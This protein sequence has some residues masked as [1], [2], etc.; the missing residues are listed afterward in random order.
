MPLQLHFLGWHESLL[1]LAAERLSSGFDGGIPDMGRMLIVTPTRQS[2]HKLREMLVRNAAERKSGLFPPR[3]VTPDFFLKN[4][5]RRI[6][7]ATEYEMIAAWAEILS[8]SAS[9]NLRALKITDRKDFPWIVGLA[10]KFCELRNLLAENSYIIADVARMGMTCGLQEPERWDALARL[11]RSYLEKLDKAGLKDANV[12]KIESD[13]FSDEIRDIEKI[14]LI[15]VCDP[16]QLVLGK[17]KNISQKKDVEIWVYAPEDMSERFDGW[18]CPIPEKWENA[19]IDF[20]GHEERIRLAGNPEAQA[21]DIVKILSEGRKVLSTADVAVSVLNE[22]LVPYVEKTF[23]DTGVRTFNP[24]GDLVSSTS[25]FHL[26]QSFSDL[27]EQENY[28]AFAKFARNP[29]FLCRLASESADFSPL[30]FLKE[31]DVYQNRHLPEKLADLEHAEHKNLKI[32]Y[33]RIHALIRE[34]KKIPLTSFVRKFLS[35]TFKSRELDPEKESSMKF[36]STAEL[37][38]D[39]LS[40]L[41]KSSIESIRLA[42]SEKLRLFVHI[43]E[44]QRIYPEHESD[45]LP[46]QG[47]LELPWEKAESLIVAGMNEGYVPESVIGDIFIPD[48]P[49]EKLGLKNNRRRFARDVYVMTSIIESR[50]NGKLYC[51]AGK[52]DVS[53]EPLKPSRLFF[54]CPSEI[55][56]QRTETLFGTPDDKKLRPLAGTFQWK[57]KVHEKKIPATLSVTD[58]RNYL[59]CPFRF[60]LKKVMKMQEVDDRKTEMDQL[61]FGEVCHKV[62]DMFAKDEKLRSSRN[63]EEIKVF[64]QVESQRLLEDIYGRHLSLSLMIQ[65]ENIKQR[66]AKFAEVQ[67]EQNAAGWE[68]ISSEYSLGAGKGVEFCGAVIKGKIDRI[69]RHSDGTMRIIDYK[70][71]DSPDSPRETHLRGVYDGTPEYS[72]VGHGDRKKSW[73]DLQLPLYQI[74]LRREKDFAGEKIICGY[75]NLPKSVLET[76]IRPW[77]DMEENYL[78][79]AETCAK[80]IVEDIS[81]GKFWPPRKVK[82]DDFE[83]IFLGVPLESVEEFK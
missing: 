41:E 83:K 73:A 19:E 31:L 23:M 38:K 22:N 20:H 76:G 78:A 70:T 6:K 65:L 79:D 59:N 66:L 3:T 49:R 1:K 80:G 72:V 7:V 12:A 54:L 58:F 25:I 10:V 17:L 18:G 39:M 14:I 11:E 24:A 34:F 33:S 53:G 68:I 44:K 75:F 16:V 62:L 81:S 5:D 77:D 21:E 71:S 2:G 15:G 52:T 36:I 28:E 8:S 35:E 9:E 13:G 46:L 42:P 60:Y 4:H 50:K 43:L 27:V 29:D 56:V 61:V 26:L 63:A 51:I 82:Y 45:M 37:V 74:L 67:A 64:V 40:E 30:D 55:L 47:W 57:L 32:A 48:L 69:E